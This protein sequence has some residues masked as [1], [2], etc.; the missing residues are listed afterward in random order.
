MQTI[1]K[2]PTSRT[3]SSYRILYLLVACIYL[4][5]LIEAQL[6][7]VLIGPVTGFLFFAG[8]LLLLILHAAR[9]ADSQLTGLLV[10]I[11]CV[12]VIRIA[13]FSV[14]PESFPPTL[15]LFLMSA[16]LLSGVV[17]LQRTINLSAWDIGLTFKRP[18]IQIGVAL[19]G[20]LIGVIQFVILDTGQVVTTAS[21]TELS[22]AGFVVLVSQSFLDE[23]LFRGIL[24]HS[25]SLVVGSWSGF[26]VALLYTTLH[27]G[28]GSPLNL[29]FILT[30]ALYFG[31]VR[32]LTGS[33][34]GIIVAHVLANTALFALLANGLLSG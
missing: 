34:V 9:E 19:S 18:L 8:L 12:V 25:S 26:Y 16:C 21:L 28:Y 22:V 20:V 33:I 1:R 3:Q 13:S 29:A 4:I 30:V 7:T 23:L 11:A 17:L 24:Q 6:A 32:G 2:L 31:L 10:G 5:G 27:I 15:W 14:P